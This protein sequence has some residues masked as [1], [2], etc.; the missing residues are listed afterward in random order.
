MLTVPIFAQDEV[1]ITLEDYESGNE[2]KPAMLQAFFIMM[3]LQS[4]I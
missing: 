4:Y 1:Q 3:H 2:R